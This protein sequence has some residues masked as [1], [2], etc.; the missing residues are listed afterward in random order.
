MPVSDLVDSG[1]LDPSQ[2]ALVESELAAR[3]ESRETKVLREQLIRLEAQL[4]ATRVIAEER[5]AMIA[6]LTNLVR[7]DAAA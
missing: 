7:P 2:V 6:V 1:D 3:R 5:A 4:D